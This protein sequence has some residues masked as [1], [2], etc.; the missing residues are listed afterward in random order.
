MFV[1]ACHLLILVLVRHLTRTALS[2]FLLVLMFTTHL[3][4]E[5]QASRLQLRT[6]PVGLQ[7][8]QELDLNLNDCEDTGLY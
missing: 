5:N 7:F 6:L 4:V 8:P 2:T 3:T 1:Q